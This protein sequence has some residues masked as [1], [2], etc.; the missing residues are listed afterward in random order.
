MYYHESIDSKSKIFPVKIILH[1]KAVNVPKHWHRSLEISYTYQGSIPDFTIAG[2]HYSTRPG[3]ILVVNS[4]EIHSVFFPKTKKRQDSLALSLIFPYPFLMKI[5]P[6]YRYRRYE[7][8][9]KELLTANNQQNLAELEGILKKF[10]QFASHQTNS[11]DEISKTSQILQILYLLTKNFSSIVTT[12]NDLATTDKPFER[13]DE[14]I[15]FIQEHAK[16]ALT[17]TKIADHFNLSTS[18]FSRNFKYY[19][20]NSVIEY[21]NLVRL[22]EAYQLLTNTKKSILVIS[23][24]VGFPNEKAFTRTFKR[25][26]KVTPTD[27]RKRLSGKNRTNIL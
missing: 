23:T 25:I 15:M 4:N 14:I 1:D 3:T 7:I 8:P 12:P 17:V 21:L 2:K 9:D 11:L 18:Y 13:L 26:Y 5:V 27:Y 24:Q 20:G 16:E 22:H 10:F 19:M 6:N